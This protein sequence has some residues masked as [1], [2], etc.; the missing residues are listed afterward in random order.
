M[1]IRNIEIKLAIDDAGAARKAIEHLADGPPQRLRQSDTYFDAGPEALL[2]LRRE[3]VDGGAVRASLIAYRRTL[4]AEPE[5]SDIR[6][7]RVDDGDGLHDALSHAL[8]VAVVVDKLRDLY[9]RGQTRI[10]V[11]KVD[12]LGAFVELE[13]VLKAGQSETDGRRIATD[14]LALLG[15]TGA[16]PQTASYRDLVRRAATSGVRPDRPVPPGGPGAD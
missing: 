7:V 13:V 15:L 8:P 1:D 11:D 6:L 4:A 5:P 10:H 2:K 12:G 3:S 14:L 16:K 9:F